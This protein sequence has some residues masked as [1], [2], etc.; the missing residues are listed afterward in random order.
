VIARATLIG[1]QSNEVDLTMPLT[2]SPGN[3]QA[4]DQAVD[5]EPDGCAVDASFYKSNVIAA[6]PLNGLTTLT[7]T[8]RLTSG[9]AFQGSASVWI[10]P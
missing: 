4:F 3:V 1:V 5:V 8:G 6:I 7:V 9:Q 2:L 10:M